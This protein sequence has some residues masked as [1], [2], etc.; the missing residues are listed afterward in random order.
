M[1]RLNSNP[2]SKMIQMIIGF[3]FMV[4]SG[5]LAQNAPIT[6][7]PAM[8]ADS[9]SII[10]IPVLV[11]DFNNIGAVS[12]T[13]SFDAVS[14]TYQSYTF[15]SV[16]STFSIQNALPGM[17]S[18]GG[19]STSSSGIT[20]ADSSV[21]FTLTFTFNGGSTG[22]TW[23]DNGSSC[24]YTGYVPDYTILND[25]P[26]STYYIDGAVSGFP[27][28]GDA[29]AITGPS[30][31]RVCDGETGILFWVEPI[32]D[33]TAY[34]WTLPQGASITAGNNTP[35]ITVSFAPAANSGN[36]EVYGTNPYGSGTSSIP[37][38]VTINFPPTIEIQPVSP[39]PVYAGSGMA[40]F[41]LSASGWALQ[42]QWQEFISSWN[43]I[44]DGGFYSG[45][46]TD[47]LVI[48]NPPYAF[49]NYRYRCLITGFCEPQA[50][51]DGNATLTVSQQALPGAAGYITG[52]AE[53]NVCAGETGISFS[54]API[55]NA[56]GYNWTL[57]LGASITAGNNTNEISV[58][59]SATALN[60]NV[61]VQ[62]TNPYGSGASSIPF[63]ITVH[64]PP[65][66]EVQPVSPEPIFADSGRALFSVTASGSQL[67]YQWQ[68]FRTEWVDIL[69]GGVYSGTSTESLV[70]NNPPLSLNGTHYRCRINGFCEPQLATDGN[71]FLTVN[72]ITA[73]NQKSLNESSL[74][75]CTIFPNPCKNF[76]TLHINLPEE[77]AIELEIADLLGRILKLPETFNG[78]RGLNDIPIETNRLKP[79]FYTVRMHLK[80][81]NHKTMHAVRLVIQP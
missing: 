78:K 11:S 53:G 68:E 67:I 37:F 49:N 26:Q 30:D 38:P 12:L 42:Y 57:P 39:E 35:Q 64:F 16:F 73:T 60:G 44:S 77:A 50:V 40:A 48:S 54:I 9:G 3:V 71:A 46:L 5:V 13:L 41:T 65:V 8:Q 20:L 51:S 62:G 19:F 66:I 36:V 17:I 7:A 63:P 2:F 28:P 45:S 34:H 24:E 1:N 6:M 75:Y 33:A 80:Y 52:P 21:L 10:S 23:Y 14:L 47:S 81:I 70:I 55:A 76:V 61:M 27:L 58:S 32:P 79:G 18:I 56:T 31:G 29:G 43:N 72:V 15:N 59:F 22:L 74:Q 4:S 25:S 69:H